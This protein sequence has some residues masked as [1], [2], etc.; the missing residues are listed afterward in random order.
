MVDIP[1]NEEYPDSLD[2]VGEEDARDTDTDNSHFENLEMQSQICMFTSLS[3]VSQI[4]GPLF[5]QHLTF[6]IK[7]GHFLKTWRRKVRSVCLTVYTV[8]KNDPWLPKT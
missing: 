1:D 5:T 4:N 3:T 6:S 8:P 7:K 2:D